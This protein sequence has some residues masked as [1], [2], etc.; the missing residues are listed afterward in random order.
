[1]AANLEKTQSDVNVGSGSNAAQS[2]ELPF[3]SLALDDVLIRQAKAGVN[4]LVKDA[5]RLDEITEDLNAQIQKLKK[6]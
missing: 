4:P 6:K 5:L 2:T 1:M 3:G